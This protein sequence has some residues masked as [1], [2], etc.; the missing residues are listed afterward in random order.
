MHPTL[1]LILVFLCVDGEGIFIFGET[2]AGKV[3]IHS[4]SDMSGFIL[5]FCFVE[6][7][8]AGIFREAKMLENQSFMCVSDIKSRRS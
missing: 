5:N 4:V 7:L 8:K 1:F 3:K 6:V 2:K